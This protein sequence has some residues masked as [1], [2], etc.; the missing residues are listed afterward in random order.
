MNPTVN[1]DID[2]KMK[3]SLL[4]VVGF[5][6]LLERLNRNLNEAVAA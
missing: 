4:D 5:I 2:I 3:F 1:I 6:C